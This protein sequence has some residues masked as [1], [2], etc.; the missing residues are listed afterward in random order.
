MAGDALG[1]VA[2]YGAPGTFVCTPTQARMSPRLGETCWQL[3]LHPATLVID[4]D[5]AVWARFTIADGATAGTS[6]VDRAD[7]GML[8]THRAYVTDVRI[9]SYEPSRPGD[10]G[11]SL[12][13]R[14]APTLHF[15][16]PG[17][18]MLDRI[19]LTWHTTSSSAR[20]GSR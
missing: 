9:G 11:S 5:S 15:Y 18:E 16:C 19:C 6:P 1:A 2:E 4:A 3:N 20:K 8:A 12:V 17:T 7:V 13:C 10:P 14:L